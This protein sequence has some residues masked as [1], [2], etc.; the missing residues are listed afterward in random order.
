MTGP[1]AAD[2]DGLGPGDVAGEPAADA[3]G[4]G[5]VV[6]EAPGGLAADDADAPGEAEAPAGVDALG[7]AD[8]PGEPLGA[9]V[10]AAEG[11][12]CSPIC[13]VRIR[14]YWRSFDVVMAAVPGR[15]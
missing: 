9:T 5:A 14:M 2:G 6:G 15:P 10:G 4:L 8:A 11:S 7:E 12:G 1:G 3:V 13:S